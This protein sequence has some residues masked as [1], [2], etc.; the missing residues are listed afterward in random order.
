MTAAET[1][2]RLSHVEDDRTR[3]DEA[4]GV[5]VSRW[6]LV[7]IAAGICVVSWLHYVTSFVSIELHEIFQRLYYVPIV[8]AAVL[9]GTKGGLTTALFSATL[10]LP[11]VILKW[12]AWPL[13]QVGQYAEIA[14]FTLVGGVTGVLADRLRAQRDRCR[15]TALELDETCRRLEVSVEERIRADRLVTIGRLASGIAHE[16][17]N[18]LG[19]LLGSLEILGAD[20]PR[21][22][23]KTEFFAIART[24]IERLNRVITEF[25]EFARPPQPTTRPADLGAV[26]N[27]AVNLAVPTL[28]LRGTAVD[29]DMDAA[30]PQAQVDVDQVERALLNLLLDDTVVPHQRRIHVSVR[31]AD[32]VAH[33][34]VSNPLSSVSLD[35]D[36]NEIFEPFP[37]SLASGGLALATARRFIENQGGRLRAALVPGCLRY[38]IE[39]PLA[40]HIR[41]DRERFPTP[42]ADAIE[43][44]A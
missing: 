12:H 39:L 40:E 18:P 31:H 33:I 35:R 27:A 29:V 19:G 1:M 22:H 37:G 24:Q 11:H 13:F 15:R 28:A 30:M 8:T 38:V 43:P 41:P 25:L 3:L 2:G 9:Y 26:V 21:G 23:R 36:V 4:S 10:F 20:I 5:G 44:H 6:W 14:I 32:H 42:V 17:R 7:A 34:V 16:I